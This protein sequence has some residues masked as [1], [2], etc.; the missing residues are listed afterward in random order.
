MKE[1]K[2]DVIKSKLV[3]K[4]LELNNEDD[5]EKRNAIIHQMEMLKIRRDIEDAKKKLT[6]NPD[7]PLTNLKKYVGTIRLF[8]GGLPVKV[9]CDATSASAARKIIQAQFNVKS[10]FKQMATN[11]R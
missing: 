5:Q 11:N 1:N 7:E 2:I 3:T 4:Q 6:E 8:S 10:F 9:A